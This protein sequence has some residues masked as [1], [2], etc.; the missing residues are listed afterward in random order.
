L[1]F[2]IA[3][4]VW[5]VRFTSASS[6]A[7]FM[8]TSPV[9]ALVWEERLT[10]H[11]AHRY[12]AALLALAG[13]CALFLP[14]LRTESAAWV[15][16]LIALA[17]SVMWTVFSRQCRTFTGVMSG[18]E[19]TGQNFW[20]AGLM[21]TPLALIEVLT[22]GV[23]WNPFVAGLH[24]YTI[25]LSGL[26]AFALWNHALAVWP[27][28]RAFLFTNL[29][30]ISTM[31]FAHVFLGEALT[32]SIWIALGLILAAVLLGQ[33]DWRKILGNRWAPAE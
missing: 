7:L 28:S 6:V 11:S 17:A 13:I 5:A 23:T 26:V 14:T 31:F 1:A 8:G 4:Y 10:R 2:Y 3:C 22:R 24:V 27:T 21:L 30:P 15:G 32:P 16:N 18:L 25:V 20:R 33:A 9:W 12:L 19:L 29:I